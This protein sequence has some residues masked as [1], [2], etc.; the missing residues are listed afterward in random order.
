MRLQTLRHR[1]HQRQQEW[2]GGKKV[3][4]VFAMMELFGEAGELANEIK[5]LQRAEEG[6]AGGVKPSLVSMSRLSDEMADVLI[7][8]DLLA[9]QYDIDL[10]VA[11]FDKFNETSRKHGL[12]TMMKVTDL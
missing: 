9:Q 4:P 2:T 10:S 7:C 3:G 12:K 6:W 5:K 11:V 8:L 1:L